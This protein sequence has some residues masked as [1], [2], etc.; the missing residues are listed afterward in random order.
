MLIIQQQ[1]FCRPGR[2]HTIKLIDGRLHFRDHRD[3]MESLNREVVLAQF[4]DKSASVCG[5]AR[6]LLAWRNRLAMSMGPGP[7]R[8][9]LED[10]VMTGFRFERMVRLRN[11]RSPK[12]WATDAA[13]VQAIADP[14]ERAGVFVELVFRELERRGLPVRPLMSGASPTNLHLVIGDG[15]DQ[16]ALQTEH[17]APL[18]IRFHTGFSRPGGFSLP[19]DNSLKHTM[20]RRNTAAP[21]NVECVLQRVTDRLETLWLFR[22]EKALTQKL[23]SKMLP[24][25]NARF[26]QLST[27]GIRSNNRCDEECY[28]TTVGDANFIF[29]TLEAAKLAAPTIQVCTDRLNRLA[30]ASQKLAERRAKIR[31]EQK[32]EKKKQNTRRPL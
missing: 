29:H 8:Q 3:D 16:P 15:C 21:G 20:V 32:H 27:V 13:D 17:I 4:G 12:D 9:Y 7:L 10:R 18:Y 14:R 28:V 30:A 31:E 11:H 25:I 2:R 6:F 19:L 23:V 22:A 5:C 26:N 24:G 1:I